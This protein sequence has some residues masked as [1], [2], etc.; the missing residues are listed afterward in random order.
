MNTSTRIKLIVV[1]AFAA[2]VAFA[3][4]I[5]DRAG[6]QSRTQKPKEE[7][8]Q[9]SSFTPVVE[10]P[11][12]VVR[13]RDKAAKS[14][15]MAAQMRLLEE[16][17]DLRRRVAENVRMTRGKPIPVGP[18]A[19]LKGGV[20]WEQLGRMTPEEIRDKGLFPYLPLPHVNHPVG[21]M[22]FP[23]AEIKLL[24]RL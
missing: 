22:L 21:G 16:R 7:D 14:R 15:V 6:A 9:Q 10:E 5:T 13:A 18:T 20:T 17:Y 11:F 3:L 19:K 4:L 23:Q 24:P 12:D 2:A 8:R 1:L